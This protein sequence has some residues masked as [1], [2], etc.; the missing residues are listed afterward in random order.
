MRI[1]DCGIAE[2]PS[3]PIRC[4]KSVSA[5]RKSEIENRKFLR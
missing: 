3:S 2:P 1:A 4:L 5:N